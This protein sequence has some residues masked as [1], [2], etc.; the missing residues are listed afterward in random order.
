MTT[1]HAELREMSLL[2][3][4]IHIKDEADRRGVPCSMRQAQRTV[5][6]LFGRTQD[7]RRPLHADPTATRA[8]R[9]AS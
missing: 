6:R 2:D 8:L 4:V 9:R 5:E 3:A 7:S 1:I